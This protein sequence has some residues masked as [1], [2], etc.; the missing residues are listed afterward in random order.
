MM[1]GP[2]LAVPLLPL[3]V[4]SAV[5][6]TID[7]TERAQKLASEPG[8]GADFGSGSGPGADFE[9][10]GVGTVGVGVAGGVA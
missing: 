8:P 7:H 10:S 2:P 1:D 6:T 9:A 4:R 5:G 3:A